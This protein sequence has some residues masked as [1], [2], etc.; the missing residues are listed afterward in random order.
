MS[1]ERVFHS[2]NIML[3]TVLEKDSSNSTIFIEMEK[4]D[5]IKIS[6]TV[7]AFSGGSVVKNLP[8]MQEKEM[9]ECLIPG[10]EEP[11]EQQM[12][13]H[14]SVFAWRTPWAEE[15]GGLQ[16]I[17]LPRV[18]HDWS[19]WEDMHYAGK[20]NLGL[21][22]KSPDRHF[23]CFSNTWSIAYKCTYV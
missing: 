20:S 23:Y 1:L 10:Q 8:A 2:I 19:N 4:R 17:V 11:L 22:D 14:S 15:P 6:Y 9:D 7:K 21:N 3:K 12:T 18:R 16:P 13:T 5:L